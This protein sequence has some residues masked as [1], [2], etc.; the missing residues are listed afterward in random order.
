LNGEE[1]E[2]VQDE[3]PDEPA[4]VEN[5]DDEGEQLPRLLASTDVESFHFPSHLPVEKCGFVSLQHSRVD[6]TSLLLW[7]NRGNDPGFRVVSQVNLPL[8]PRR[9]P[10]I[11]YDGRRIVVL[12]Q[13]HIDAII[14]VYHVFC[15]NED[16]GLF[17]PSAS[18]TK[19]S[20]ES[21]G[22]YK[23]HKHATTSRS[24]CQPYSIRRIG[25]PRKL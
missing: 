9:K 4:I 13:D 5:D 2:E 3:G 12:G 10:R 25:R 24:L 8:S 21:V 23:L 19:L 22:V 7:K 18:E 11:H 16:V 15:S 6:G 1:E 17:S 14:L 20:E